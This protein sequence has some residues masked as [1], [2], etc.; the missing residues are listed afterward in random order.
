MLRTKFKHHCQK[1][2][3]KRIVVDEK[4]APLI[5]WMNNLNGVITQ[6]SCEGARTVKESGWGKSSIPYVTF[7]CFFPTSLYYIFTYI[8]P[9]C[10]EIK[11]GNY[12]LHHGPMRYSFYFGSPKK[13]KECISNLPKIKMDIYEV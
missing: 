2:I 4:I 1:I 10:C 13:L 12:P 6:F 3:Q 11:M 5:R 7:N 8:A 9:Y